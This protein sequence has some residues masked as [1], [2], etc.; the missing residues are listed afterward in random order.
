MFQLHEYNKLSRY[1]RLIF[2]KFLKDTQQEKNKKAA[3]N[4]WSDDWKYRPET[5]PY[6]LEKTDRFNSNGKFNI[7][8]DDKTVVGCSG[9][10][11]SNFCNEIA[12]LGTRTWINKIYRNQYISRDFLLPDEKK[13]AIDNNFKLIILTFNEYNKNL[14]Q[15][16]HRNRIGLNKKERNFYHFGYSGIEIVPY[17]V[18][19]QYTKQYVMYEKLDKNWSFD[20]SLIKIN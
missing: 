3:V 9:V 6:I 1:D 15:L 20:W 13:W 7:I 19:I 11:R 18:E 14:M 17:L 10:Y 2:F 5:L 12:V 4:M 16:W 8:F